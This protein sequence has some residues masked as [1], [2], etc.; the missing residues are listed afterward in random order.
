MPTSNAE[1]NHPDRALLFGLLLDAL[2]LEEVIDRARAAID[3]HERFLI[4]VVNAAK[5]VKMRS[6][7]LLRDSLLEADVL[8]A[9]GQSVVWASRFLGHPLPERVTGIDLFE[10]LLEVA[11]A[12]GK[13][14]YF[15]G[16]RSDVLKTMVARV[17]ERFPGLRIAGSRDGYFTVEESEDVAVTI[18]ASTADMLFLGITSPKKEIFLAQF[19]HVLGVPLLHGVGGSFD[20]LAGI[21]RRAPLAWQRLGLEWAYRLKQEPRRLWNRYLPTNTAFILLT[22]RERIRPTARYT[23]STTPSGTQRITGDPA[24]IDTTAAGREQENG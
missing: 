2:T 16:A 9:D 10:R 14:V 24:A 19:G 3:G 12:S 8:L 17:R 7:P 20:I 13:S 5:V 15:L 23:R 18:A 21:T 11:A 22:L 4:G 1:R 6:D